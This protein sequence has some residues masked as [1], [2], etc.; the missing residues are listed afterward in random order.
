MA[1]YTS[2]PFT[3]NLQSYLFKAANMIND[4]APN[5]IGRDA[6]LYTLYLSNGDGAIRYIGFWDAES[7]ASEK[8]EVLIPVKNGEDMV[9]NID[10]GL[11]FETA[12]TVNASTSVAGGNPTDFDASLFLAP[13]TPP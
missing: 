6:V 10:T 7:I 13:P 3:T 4:G 1:T 11:Y 8:Q 2:S 12:V 9:V 5:C